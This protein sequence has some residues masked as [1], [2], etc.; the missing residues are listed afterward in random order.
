MH[1]QLSNSEINAALCHSCRMLLLEIS[2]Q[3]YHFKV[4]W[5]FLVQSVV[6][7]WIRRMQHSC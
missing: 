6:T 2:E 3:L 1:L 4:C 7:D 5:E